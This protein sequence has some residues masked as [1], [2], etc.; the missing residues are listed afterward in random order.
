[1]ASPAGESR[2]K[3]RD[4]RSD[5]S[6]SMRI[7]RQTLDLIDDAASVAGKS[8]TDFVLESAR[9]HAIDVLIDQRLFLLD[10]ERHE[11]FMRALDDPPLPSARLKQLMRSDKAP[12]ER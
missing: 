6:I 7:S 4:A 10:D 12:W 9:R 8:R 3:A 1:M 11:A 5:A 2:T